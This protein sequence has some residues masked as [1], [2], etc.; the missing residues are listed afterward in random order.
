MRNG[1]A[2]QGAA[3][4]LRNTFARRCITR[5]EATES[6]QRFGAKV[7]SQ[8]DDRA[9]SP[10][11]KVAK[12]YSG[13]LTSRHVACHSWFSGTRMMIRQWCFLHSEWCSTAVRMA[14]ASTCARTAAWFAGIVRK[15]HV[16]L[17]KD[18]YRH[19]TDIAIAMAAMAMHLLKT[20][21]ARTVSQL[22]GGQ[23]SHQL[24]Q[25]PAIPRLAGRLTL[26]G[27]SSLPAAPTIGQRSLGPESSW[28]RGSTAN[29]RTGSR[30]LTGGLQH[31]HD[32]PFLEAELTD[33]LPELVQHCSSG[34]DSSPVPVLWTLL[35]DV[36][37]S[38]FS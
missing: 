8:V 27:Q 32:V 23:Q 26:K 22:S 34:A 29:Q 37:C 21:F 28:R 5:P 11:W 17:W 4:P 14:A 24:A 25:L 9:V 3:T 15:S 19:Q 36:T 2:Y 7:Y 18:R 30:T 10:Y 35:A 13:S 16:A 20:V 38:T 33:L 1:S 31:V 6:R 12:L